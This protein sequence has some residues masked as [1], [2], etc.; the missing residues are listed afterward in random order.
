LIPDQAPGGY[1]EDPAISERFVVAPGC[2]RLFRAALHIGQDVEA[3]SIVATLM[4]GGIA[5]P[6]ATW[7]CGS[8]VDWLARDGEWVPQGRPLLVLRSRAGEEP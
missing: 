1:G 6:I 3:G 5:Q 8:L 7:I 2:G 4:L